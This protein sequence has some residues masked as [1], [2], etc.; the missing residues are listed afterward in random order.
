MT[1]AGVFSTPH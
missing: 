1:V